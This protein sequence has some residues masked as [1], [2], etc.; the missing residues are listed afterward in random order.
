MYVKPRERIAGREQNRG[1]AAV[2][3]WIR[4][5]SVALPLLV[6]REN[7]SVEL[8]P[9]CNATNLDTKIR[10]GR[11]A[12]AKRRAQSFK[13]ED[14]AC[15][16]DEHE[17]WREPNEKFRLEVALWQLACEPASEEVVQVFD[18]ATDALLNRGAH[19]YSPNA[20]ANLPPARLPAVGVAFVLRCGT[21]CFIAQKLCF[22]SCL[23]GSRCI[24]HP[25]A[26]RHQI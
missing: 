14:P 2:V 17:L 4:R 22:A 8:A 5:E 11:V 18:F 13:T 26:E 21:R 12:C 20:R 6:G 3:G 16:W 23:T 1:N 9:N 7:A 10:I 19:L 15:R 25:S 24:V